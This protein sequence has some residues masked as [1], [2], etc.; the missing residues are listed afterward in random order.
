M[1]CYP[2]WNGQDI[3]GVRNGAAINAIYFTGS[4]DNRRLHIPSLSLVLRRA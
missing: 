3:W 4:G 2:Y 1:G